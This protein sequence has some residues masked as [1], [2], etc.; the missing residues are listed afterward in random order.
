MALTAVIIKMLNQALKELRYAFKIF[1]PYRKVR[2]VSVFGSA[3]TAPD[4][5]RV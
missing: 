1:S 5:P 2:K 4:A 3:R